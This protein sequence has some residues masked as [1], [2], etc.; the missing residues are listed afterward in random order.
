MA[1]VGLGPIAGACSPTDSRQTAVPGPTARNARPT[2]M[3]TSGNAYRAVAIE[4]GGRVTGT[5]EFEGPAPADTTVHPT[6]DADVCGQSLVDV[7]VDHCGPRLARAVVWLT[8][9]VAGKPM[10]FTRRYD[11][12][13]VGCRIMPRVQAAVVGG[14]VNVGNGDPATHRTQFRRLATG[15]VLAAIQETEAGAVV[16]S[17]AILA[18]P[19]LVEIRCDLHPWMHGWIAVF[20]HPYFTTTD[21][22]GGFVIDS[23]PPGHYAISVW[24]ERFGTRTDSV[25]VTPGGSASIA[26]KFGR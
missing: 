24:H 5:V 12:T 19:G 18:I 6:S 1:L 26:L 11:V 7:S 9:V 13:T 17:A 16:P 2:L 3:I 22:D 10:P 15:S 14:T 25:T 8:G 21:A 23:V 4:D 20:D